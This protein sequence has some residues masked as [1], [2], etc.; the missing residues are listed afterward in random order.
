MIQTE[1]EFT[2]LRWWVTILGLL[3][4]LADILT[5]VALSVSFFRGEYL[6][7]AGLTVLFVVV[8]SMVTQIFSYTWYRDDMRNTLVQT[9]TYQKMGGLV[10]IHVTQMGMFNRYYWLLRMGHRVLWSRPP[11]PVDDS[12]DFHLHLFGQAA[13]LSM[14]KLFETFLE[15]S[16]QLL[17]QLY[18]MLSSNHWSML[19]C[20]SMAFSLVNIAWAL[21]DYRRC[22]RR[23]LSKV[24]EMPCGFP[25][26]FY[27]LYKL[28][29]ITS[30][31]LC[32]SL[33]LVV[34]PFSLL[35][36]A[37][38][39]LA[40][41]LWACQVQT[42]FCKSKSLEVLYRI[43]VG[44]ILVFTFFNVKGQNTRGHMSVY[45]LLYGLV[46][47]SGPCL[48]ILVKPD[49][50]AKEFFWPMTGVIFGGTLLGLGCLCLF[51]SCLHPTG[52]PMEADEV[53]GSMDQDDEAEK[54]ET[55]T[56]IRSF[57]QL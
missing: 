5:D 40:G 9:G 33:F 18:I 28:F 37:G 20:V 45:Y 16:P 49:M 35:G 23:S 27:F 32:I 13:D 25:T 24:R 34:S 4:Y 56:R 6:L 36:L 48:L 10:G 39:G 52:N 17:L 53:D 3:F 15:S 38:L 42:D 29:T 22:L 57:L 41:T 12:R 44:I 1:S 21:V 50:G 55:Q 47:F 14:L 7:W 30:H 26:L 46:N 19:Q 11:V 2:K 51:Y 31:I 8:G 54:P 43:V